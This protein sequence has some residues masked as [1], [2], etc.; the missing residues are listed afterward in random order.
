MYYNINTAPYFKKHD[1]ITHTSYRPAAVI[2]SPYVKSVYRF[3][4]FGFF[5]VCVVDQ[6]SS[7]RRDGR[8]ETMRKKNTENSVLLLLLQL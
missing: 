6:N 4:V 8:A 3:F 1:I 5:R 2:C 7:R